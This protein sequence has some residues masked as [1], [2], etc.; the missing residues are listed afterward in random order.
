MSA[1]RLLFI[2][3]KG[4][5]GK[6]TVAAALGQRAVELGQRVLIVETARDGRLSDL[7]EGPR[8]TSGPQTLQPG[9]E[10]LCVEPRALVEQY[11]AGLL[12]I[13][14]VSRRLLS[15][16]TFNALTAAAPGI[17]DFL[18]LEQILGWVEPGLGRR[19]YGVVIV[20]GPATGHALKLL[21]VPR[22]VLS[23]VPAGPL[24]TTAKRL[25]TLLGNDRRTQVVIV[26][27]AEEMSVRETIE[28]WEALTED[29]AL[30]VAR[31]V[32]NRVFPR[33]FSTAE[34][35]LLEA[36]GDAVEPTLAAARYSIACRRE[37]ERHVSHLRRAVD[38]GPIVL[39]QLFTAEVHAADLR[40]FGVLLGRAILS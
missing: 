5:T 34:A 35:R 7:F 12:R 31:P 30:R 33:H 28:T 22:N 11:F 26:A 32:L 36:E 40:H 1:S 16:R 23:T 6:T 38:R 19:R 27:V 15:S 17:T 8:L 10:A 18:L 4:G 21:R 2:T 9:L 14:L 20:D 24:A 25:L 37:A 29:M 3:G 39:R 13:P